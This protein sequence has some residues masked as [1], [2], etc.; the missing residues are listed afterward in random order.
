MK[1]GSVAFARHAAK[2]VDRLMRE[3]K[4]GNLWSLAE[5]PSD[6]EGILAKW[7]ADGEPGG[8]LELLHHNIENRLRDDHNSN[9]AQRQPLNIQRAREGAS[10]MAAAVVRFTIV[11][12]GDRQTR[13]RASLSIAATLSAVLL[14]KTLFLT[15]D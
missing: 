8:R 11:S 3:I 1:K 9:R 5:R 6:L 2:K 12:Y 14:Q 13:R 4:C 10:R 7:D 15:P